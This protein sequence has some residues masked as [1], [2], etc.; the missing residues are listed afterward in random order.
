[1]LSDLPLPDE[2]ALAASRLL[3]R[4]ICEEA[5][6]Q[7]GGL[8]FDRFMELALYTPGLGYYSGG[9]RKFGPAGDFVTA[10]ELSPLF[11]RCLAAQVAQV[12]AQTGGGVVVEFGAG[13]GVLAADMLLELARREALPEA[14]LILEVSAELRER[15]FRL[16]RERVPDLAPRVSWLDRLPEH[17]VTGVVIANE[18][19]DA[20]PVHRFRIRRGAVQSQRVCCG[21]DGLSVRWEAA[22]AAVRS[23]VEGITAKAGLAEGY[24]SEVCLQVAPWITSLASCIFR[25]LAL[26]IDYGDPRAEYYHPPRRDGTLLCH[27]RHRAHADPLFLPGLQDITA[28]VDFTAVAEAAVAAGLSVAGF[29]TQAHF[30]LGCGIERFLSDAHRAGEV[31]GLRAA[32]QAKR[33]ILPTEMGERFKVLALTRDL[34]IPLLGFTAADLRHR[35]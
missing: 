23:A 17:P 29:T 10:P 31:A 14:Y 19:L 8:A 27:Y 25:G 20:L 22:P 26:L 28:H 15:Q 1:M 18:V 21:A 34:D 11:S 3:V 4:R 12:L 30:L 33:L 35:L 9:S 2:H 32:E 6:L 24:C 5:S 16:L 13:S 7:G